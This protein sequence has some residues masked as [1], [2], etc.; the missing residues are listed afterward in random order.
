MIQ[1]SPD[2]RILSCGTWG[3]RCC[4]IV[5]HSRDA[6]FRMASARFSK[7]CN[8]LADPLHLPRYKCQIRGTKTIRNQ[9]SAQHEQ[10]KIIPSRKSR[11]FSPKFTYNIDRSH[12]SRDTAKSK[13]I[14][15]GRNKKKKLS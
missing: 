3:G 8:E 2:R 12:S 13:F 10:C 11:E 15:I 14:P 7:Q 4:L 1:N 6:L 9:T 5:F